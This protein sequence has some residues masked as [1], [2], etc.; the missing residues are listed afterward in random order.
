LA[1][2]AASAGAANDAR[3]ARWCAWLLV[4]TL[5]ADGRL[6]EASRTAAAAAQ[7]CAAQGAYSWQTRFLA[8]QLWCAALRGD[9]IDEVVGR[10]TELSD[11]TLPALARG[12]LTAAASLAEAD[13]GLL[14]SARSRLA[15]AA[16]VPGA[17]ALL[18]WVAREA[19]WLD[20][21]PEPDR[22]DY[23]GDGVSQPLM[24]G[25]RQITSRWAAFDAGVP[26]PAGAPAGGSGTSAGGQAGG[27]APVTALVGPA[28]VRA[29]LDAWAA[30]DPGGFDRAAQAW[31]NLARREEVRCLLAHGLRER[32]PAAA[33]PPLLVAERLA[34]EAG[35]VVL[36]GRTRRAL[37]RHAVHRDNRGP[38][39][40]DALTQREREVLRLV[41]HGEPTRR[42]AGQL[43]ISRETVETHIRSGMRKLGAHTR[44]EAAALALEVLE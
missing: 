31:H 19:A 13:G 36:L 10:A 41:A 18:D 29:T 25:L 2:A 44:T 1:G 33:V 20:G 40:G 3:T 34:E 6:A 38:R 16:A 12:Y 26:T 35:M 17:A 24:S 4:E 30:A 21:Q 43:G 8:A 15:G 39:T 32:D 5:A 22:A 9:A 42:I 37:R 23:T 11:R 7:A 28:P 14:R 27:V